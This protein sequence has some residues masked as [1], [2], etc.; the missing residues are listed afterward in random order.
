MKKAEAITAK[1]VAAWLKEHYGTCKDKHFEPGCVCCQVSHV[2]RMI[3]DEPT[4]RAFDVLGGLSDEH[5][6]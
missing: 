1:Q 6:E 5:P 3:L 4:P 2:R